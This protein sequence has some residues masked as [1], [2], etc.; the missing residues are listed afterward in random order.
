MGTHE[1]LRINVLP[2]PSLPHP[3][4][5]RV[6]SRKWHTGFKDMRESELRSHQNLRKMYGAA[7]SLL[8]SDSVLLDL[9]VDRLTEAL[10]LHG[11]LSPSLLLL[12]MHYHTDTM[13]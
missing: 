4:Q 2:P 3:Q 13:S 5:Y 6:V 10:R 11:I 9:Y 12:S 8:F 1:E 7:C